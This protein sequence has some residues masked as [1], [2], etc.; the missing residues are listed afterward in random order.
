MI[1]FRRDFNLSQLIK[2]YQLIELIDLYRLRLNLNQS[3][4]LINKAGGVWCLGY[5]FTSNFQI[6]IL[7][8][9]SVLN[10]NQLDSFIIFKLFKSKAVSMMTTQSEMIKECNLGSLLQNESAREGL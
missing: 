6:T 9:L 5:Q 2:T 7:I 4:T 3:N 10:Y 8:L 1:S